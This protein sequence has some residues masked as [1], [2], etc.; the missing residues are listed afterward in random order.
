MEMQQVSI[1]FIPQLLTVEQTVNQPNTCTDLLQQAE[2][3]E[4]FMTLIIMGD[5]TWI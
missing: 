3:D 4:N 5:E 2:A 1:K